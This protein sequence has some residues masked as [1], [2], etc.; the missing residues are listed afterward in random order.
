MSENVTY[1]PGAVSAQL[2]ELEVKEGLSTYV[3]ETYGVDHGGGGGEEA[4]GSSAVHGGEGEALGDDAAEA[5]KIDEVGKFDAI[6][7]GAGGGDDRVLEGELP[8]IDR[9]VE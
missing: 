5:P 1:D 9:E 6:A 7:E 2:G 8:D 4:R 3:L